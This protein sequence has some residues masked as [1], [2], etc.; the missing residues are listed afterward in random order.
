MQGLTVEFLFTSDKLDVIINIKCIKLC[1]LKKL[2]DYI[3]FCQIFNI[4]VKLN[5][6]IFIKGGFSLMKAKKGLYILLTALLAFSCMF[7]N[8]AF[9]DTAPSIKIELDKTSAAVGDIIKASIVVNNVK[10][11]AGYQVNIKY[12]PTVLEAINLDTGAAFTNTTVPQSGT[13]LNNSEYGVLPIA[14]HN[15]SQGILNFSK[16]YTNLNSYKASGSAETTGTVAVIGFK[17]RR[18]EE[19]KIEFAQTSTMPTAVSGVLLFDWDGNKL[20]SGYSIINPPAINATSNTN[21]PTP[22]V[23][24]TPLE[25]TTSTPT[26]TSSGSG[27]K[28]EIEPKVVNNDNTRVIYKFEQKDLETA[29]QDLTPDSKGVKKVDLTLAGVKGATAYTQEFPNQALLSNVLSYKINMITAYATLELPANMLNTDALASKVRSASK[30]AISVERDYSSGLSSDIQGKIGNRP[31]IKLSLN[32]NDVPTDWVNLESPVKVYIPYALTQEEKS[33]IEHIVVLRID[34]NGNAIPVTNGRYDEK[35]KSVTFTTSQFGRFAVAY[36]HRTFNDL[37]SH[38]WAKHQ[39]E[40]L[41]SKGVINGTSETTFA[42]QAYITRADFMVLLVK[43][44]DLNAVVDSNFDDVPADAY[45]YNQIGIAK[46]LG[47][48]TGVGDNKYN[49][50]AQ[51]TRQDMM[52]LITRALMVTGKINSEGTADVIA[53]YSDKDDIAPYAVT[54][55][56]TLVKEGIVLGSNNMINPRGNASRA[57]LAAIVYKI[58]N[59]YNN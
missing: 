52:V 32:V 15:V 19:T 10:G 16:A 36:V 46:K 41:A 13:I 4:F 6:I 56:A 30:V 12:D 33:S 40:V 45:Y 7:S 51:I 26:P 35:T 24:T 29:L 3:I 34:N 42:P 18:A 55:V 49:P 2:F 53:T 22:I 14:S 5:I 44:L 37:E 57:E 39:I 27:K 59:N 38:A 28:G 20:T 11:F 50:K 25:I 43:A 21:I 58:Y 1:S 9:A 23:V 47:I 17:V 48:T 31:M 8:F 54:G